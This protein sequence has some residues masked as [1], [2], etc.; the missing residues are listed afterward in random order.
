MKV[1]QRATAIL[2]ERPRSSLELAA[3]LGTSLSVTATA[4]NTLDRC[5]ILIRT[6]EVLGLTTEGKAYVA[7]MHPDDSPAVVNPRA[8]GDVNAIVAHAIATQPTS[9]FNLAPDSRPTKPA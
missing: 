2:A 8:S 3:A 6:G 4:V 9:V 5:G 1:W 7:E